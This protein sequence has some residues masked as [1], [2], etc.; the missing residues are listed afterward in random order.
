MEE[1]CLERESSPPQPME[2]EYHLCG[3]PLAQDPI[4]PPSPAA[5]GEKISASP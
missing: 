5:G 4:A 3:S 1:I 2:H